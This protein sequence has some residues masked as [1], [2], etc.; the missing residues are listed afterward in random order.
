[1]ARDFSEVLQQAMEFYVAGQ[2][3]EARALLLD[4]VRADPKL[5]AGWMFLSYTL[6][7]PV[8]K[9][10]CLR[11]VLAIN[12]ENIEAQAALEQLLGTPIT[13]SAE[14]GSAPAAA[15]PPSP[16]Q[17]A[18]AASPS[19]PPATSAPMP[20]AAPAPV[21]A[22][23]KPPSSVAQT[24]ET[25]APPTVPEAK[26]APAVQPA[27]PAPS[28]APTMV[29]AS[30]FTVGIDH[31]NDNLSVIPEVGFPAPNPQA[32][33]PPQPSVNPF[34]PQSVSH[35]Q[36]PGPPPLPDQRQA[37]A[38]AAGTKI[39]APA[40]PGQLAKAAGEPPV[41][42]TSPLAQ[43]AGQPPARNTGQLAQAPGQP[44]VRKTGQLAQAA[45]QPP[46]R[47]TGQLAQAAGQPPARKTGQIAATAAPE[48][49]APKKQRSAGCTCL[50]VGIIL[51]LIAAGIGV[52]LYLTGN[53]PIFFT[54]GVNPDE[55]V[56]PVLQDTPTQFQLP[57]RAT[58]TPTPTLTRTA[59][60]TYTPTITPSPTLAPPDATVQA[61]MARLIKEVEDIRGLKME[62]SVPAY[63][64]DRDQAEAILQADLDRIDYSETIRIEAK[65]LAVLGFIKPTYDL[66][67]YATSRQA[68]GVLGFYM[69]YNRT[70][71][72]IGNRFAGMERWTFSHEFDHALVHSVYPDSMASQGDP[73][74]ANDSQRCEAIRA[75]VE[76]D[77]MLVDEMW[78]DQYAT[79]YDERDIALSP[80]QLIMP[81]EQNTPAYMYPSMLFTYLGGEIF[82][83]TLWKKGNWALVNEVYEKLPDSTEQILH[84]EKFLAGEKPVA[85]DVPELAAAIGE[86]WSLI[87]SD[88]LGEFKSYLLLAFG[89]DNPAQLSSDTAAE[90]VAGWGGDHYLVFESAEREELLLT[91]EWAW[92]TD[93]DAAQFFAALED[94]LDKRFR[95]GAVAAVAGKCWSMNDT[96]TCVYRSGKSILWL[97]GPDMGIFDAVRLAYGNY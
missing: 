40:M 61:D 67:K 36:K 74:C 31:V 45:G 68:D 85:M 96:S 12:P 5:E 49:L 9:A 33:R 66:A 15:L 47:K 41:R 55:T 13:G 30:P 11:K 75:L 71:Y 3:V 70:M 62:G 50:V 92:D 26:A 73:L 65:A 16:V 35:I 4:I 95:G 54:G 24:A 79:A 93:A 86:G 20:P 46:V 80:Y 17:P 97:T 6:D 77:A 32:A 63:I 23:N 29:H 2:L 8:R 52:G 51:A 42:N 59:T 43:A 21:S 53:L 10:D 22:S 69:P 37:P 64:V 94:Y 81:P 72:I 88:S 91:A 90:A 18:Q 60:I 82:V 76:G 38:A 84:P 58:D 19:A 28:E 83:Y 78:R 87:K 14:S 27:A 48:A 44:P 25:T 56:P 1:M 39:P 57:P 89:A 7:D 34:P